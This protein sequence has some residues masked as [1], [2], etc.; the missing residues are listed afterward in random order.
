ML[1]TGKDDEKDK[2]DDDKDDDDEKK[3]GAPGADATNPAGNGTAPLID[4]KNSTKGNKT[5]ELKTTMTTTTTTTE[6]VTTTRR[7]KFVTPNKKNLP[8][9]ENLMAPKNYYEPE[10]NDKYHYPDQKISTQNML[11]VGTGY[12][13]AFLA[14]IGIGTPGFN[15]SE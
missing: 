3:P 14:Y 5:N 9:P 4:S 8:V 7:K 2:D 12:E 10:N 1:G 13:A 11:N 6:T 15:Q